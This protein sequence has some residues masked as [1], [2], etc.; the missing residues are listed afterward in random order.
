MAFTIVALAEGQLPAATAALYTSPALT[1]T[2]VKSIVFTNTDV[3]GRIINLYINSAGTPRR[4]TPKDLS[5]DAGY[6]G[7]CDD[8]YTLS[9]GDTIE[10]DADAATIVDYVINGVQEA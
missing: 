4:I 9:A 1:T 2:I 10:G 5:L 7:V 3:V 6:M 8:I